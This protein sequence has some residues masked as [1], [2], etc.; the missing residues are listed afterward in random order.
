[1]PAN[2]IKSGAPTSGRERLLEAAAAEFAESG[3]VGASIA[4]IAARAGVSKST[5]FHHFA[6]KEDL[7]I[8]VIGD[9]VNDFGQRID[10]ALAQEPTGQ[11]ALNRFQHE[12]LMHLEGHRQVARLILR[13]LQDPALG[14]RKPLIMELLSTNFTRL[15]RHLESQ[16]ASGRIRTDISCQVTALIMF[17]SNAFFFQHAEDL[18]ELPEN[19]FRGDSRDFARAVIDILYNGLA[20]NALD[21]D[22]S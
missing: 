18:A 2:E 22:D 12:H 14:G 1:M 16:Q 9:A 11:S 10:H 19:G 6:S 5:V 21:G 4:T 13:E 3:Y 7:Y 15:V 17:A 20:P 8:A